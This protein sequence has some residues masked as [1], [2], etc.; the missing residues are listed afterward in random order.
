MQREESQLPKPM[1]SQLPPS[2][3]VCILMMFLL[4]LH[5]H[6]VLLS[7]LFQSLSFCFCRGFVRVLPTACSPSSAME[8]SC[9][10]LPA[11]PRP[12][13]AGHLAE[14]TRDSW[15]H[16]QICWPR[17]EHQE[18][19]VAWDLHGGVQPQELR[20]EMGGC[21]GRLHHLGEVS[22][23]GV[24]LSSL[25]TSLPSGNQLYRELLLCKLSA[26]YFRLLLRHL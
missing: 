26:N 8:G 2:C 23:S 11:A 19:A 13:A 20:V 17:E 4:H 3:G 25:R 15:G 10:L 14:L 21:G 5:N 22:P 6:P 24:L 7:S 1:F 18:P 16:P 9:L 12:D